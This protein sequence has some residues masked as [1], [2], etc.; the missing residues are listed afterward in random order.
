MIYKTEKDE[1]LDFFTDSSNYKGNCQGVYF[2]SSEED[3]VEILKE[4]SKT[5]QQIT[6]AG[7]G[8]G[9]NGGRVPDGGVAISM[10]QLNKIKEIN[11]DKKFAIVEPGVLLSDFQDDV[12]S[13]GLFYPPDPTERNCYLGATVANNSSGAKTFKYGPTRDYVLALRIVL[14]DG[15][16]LN[17]NRGE[18]YAYN[19]KLKLI[20]E[21]NTAIEIDLPNYIMPQTKHAAGYFCKDEMDAIDLFIGSEG[22]LG[23]ISEIKLKLVN[24]PEGVLSSII[25][26]DDEDDAFNFLFEARDLSR[27][28]SDNQ[29]DALG[30][31]YFD[32]D[33]LNY[34]KD[35]YPQIPDNTQGAVWF[36]QE[37]TSITEESIL[38]EWMLLIEKYNGDLETAWIATNEVD[39]DRFKDFRH[40]IS[41]KIT[42]YITQKNIR[43][44]GTDTAVPN[45]SFYNYY[46]FAKQ[47]V[48]EAGIKSVCYGHFGDSHM[49]LNMLP[50][51]EEQFNNA[52]Q[53]YSK[54]MLEAVQ[55]KGTISAEH[56]IGKLKR[57]HLNKMFKDEDITAMAKIKKVLDPELIL[58]SGNIIDSKYFDGI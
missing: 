6:V 32:A 31:E 22:T 35:D 5:N 56:G 38:D 23:I 16:I 30:L 54:L 2:P 44:V 10:S 49:H 20:T 15:D 1:I 17:I 18:T 21:A 40:A 34:M 57:K 14:P 4:C 55:Q 8:T 47:L 50:E 45:V 13:K 53:I 9:L 58:N 48:K 51:D 33:S 43:K 27:S 11:Y 39:R 41:W 12:E 7:N 42:E 29:I 36:E 52:Q 28:N 25:F 3:I 26:F 37:I 46:K 19:G 24:I